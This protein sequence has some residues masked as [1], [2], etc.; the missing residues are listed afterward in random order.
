MSESLPNNAES[1]DWRPSSHITYLALQRM[2]M[3][4][5]IEDARYARDLWDAMSRCYLAY[6]KQTKYPTYNFEEIQDQ[7]RWELSEL[8]AKLDEYG[9]FDGVEH[10][11]LIHS[12]QSGKINH[13]LSRKEAEE[14]GMMS[15][16]ETPQT[17]AREVR[18]TD[19]C[20]D[21]A[22]NQS[23]MIRKANRHTMNGRE[24][25]A[26]EHN[27]WPKLKGYYQDYYDNNRVPMRSLRQA[28]GNE[29]WKASGLE[30][31][32]P[33]LSS[34]GA[35][36]IDS[37]VQSVESGTIRAVLPESDIS[38]AA[39]AKFLS[40]YTKQPVTAG[41]NDLDEFKQKVTEIYSQYDTMVRAAEVSMDAEF[42]GK[43]LSGPYKKAFGEVQQ[44]HLDRLHDLHPALTPDAFHAGDYRS[45]ET[46][47]L[48]I[49]NRLSHEVDVIAYSRIEGFEKVMHRYRERDM[50]AILPAGILDQPA[51][52][53]QYDAQSCAVAGFRM[54]YQGITGHFIPETE[55][56]RLFVELYGARFVDDRAYLK[57]IETDLFQ[58]S[59]NVDVETALYGGMSLGALSRYL[60]KRRA[61][62]PDAKLFTVANLR[63]RSMSRS[64]AQHRV[65]LLEA[66]EEN[67]HLLDPNNDKQSVMTKYN[68]LDRWSSTQN[69]GYIVSAQ[70][71]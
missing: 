30:V 8:I 60:Q 21:G 23:A 19:A 33:T 4:S 64:L 51:S 45:R 16:Y 11:S 56:R 17:Y 55:T 28:Q 6:I 69:S 38:I 20:P 25:Q 44:A 31:C 34:L 63:T 36:S 43:Y 13:L 5:N 67:V 62:Q 61:E 18:L 41:E 24:V 22:L 65:V 49:L 10:G 68:F 1:N 59:Y 46:Q 7:K 71:R 37:F 9:D 57:M 39:L 54:V 66:D 14:T 3:T 40:S 48:L 42:R 70:P 50:S 2:F 53:K 47:K 12:L 15:W 58:D 27:V 26:F 52:T 35:I 32:D 29:R